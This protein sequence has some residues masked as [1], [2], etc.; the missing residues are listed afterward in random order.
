MKKT[1][2]L[3]CLLTLTVGGTSIAYAGDAFLGGQVGLS[4]WSA[5]DMS[6]NDLGFGG[7]GGYRV[8]LGVHNSL[9][10]EAGYV[11]FGKVSRSIDVYIP[12]LDATVKGSISA[13]AVTVGPVYRLTFLGNSR[14]GGTFLQ[15]RGGYMHWYGRMRASVAG[16]GHASESDD[17]DGW[18]AG[19]GIGT[20][21]T[22]HF[23]VGVNYAY[24]TAKVEG[25]RFKVHMALASAEFRF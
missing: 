17:G 21:I 20:Y 10:V 25:T 4:H 16:Y 15:L 6:D 24:H 1:I 14:V 5:E 18:Y 2:L 22:P 8:N 12:S 11:D 9:G 23:E 3:L 13:H 19:A 7:Y